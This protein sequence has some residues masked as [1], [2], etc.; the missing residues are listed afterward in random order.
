[1]SHRIVT[2]VGARPQIALRPPQR[3]VE[4][5]DRDHAGDA[6]LAGDDGR[7]ARRTAQ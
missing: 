7:V 1:M 6:E 4:P 3:I 2:V 5:V